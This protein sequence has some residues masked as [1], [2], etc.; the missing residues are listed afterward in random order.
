MAE[1]KTVAIGRALLS[2]FDKTGIADFAG[3][4]AAAGAEL[5]ST[6]GTHKLISEAGLAVREISDLTG[7]PEMMDGRV[8]TL[9]PKVHGGLLAGRDNPEHKAAMDAHAIGP[10]DLVAVNL[11]PFEKTVASGADYATIIEWSR[12]TLRF[13]RDSRRWRVSSRI[14]SG[15]AVKHPGRA[16]HAHRSL[17]SWP[18][19]PVRR[20]RTAGK[21]MQN[22]WMGG[23]LRMQRGQGRRDVA[24]PDMARRRRRPG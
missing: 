10:I 14:P 22:G 17:S 12:D 15:R 16:V 21:L 8:K 4:L 20:T 18:T 11:Y 9:H 13:S 5:I 3:A 6:G 24:P 23:Y 1:G 2:V 7:F 19:L